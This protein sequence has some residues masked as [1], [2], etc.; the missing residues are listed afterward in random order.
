MH[1]L[2]VVLALASGVQKGGK[3]YVKG[4]AVVMT[5]KA[6]G[7]GASI[8][9][10]AG[11]EVTW[12]GA[13]A[14][15]KSMHLIEHQGKKGYVPM[16]SLTPNRASEELQSTAPPVPPRPAGGTAQEEAALASVKLLTASTEE[17]KS[18]VAEHVKKS[19]LRGGR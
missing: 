18:K 19:G 6:D 8:L 15:N 3:M 14:K 11:T 16:S 12:H 2:V 7:A 17:Q 1:L 13:D 4:D 10:P 9:L 5:S